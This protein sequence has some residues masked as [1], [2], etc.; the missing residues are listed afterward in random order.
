VSAAKHHARQIIQRVLFDHDYR[1]RELQRL[2]KEWSKQ[3]HNIYA[4]KEAG[5]PIPH[6]ASSEA[7]SELVLQ[8]S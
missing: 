2:L 6:G 8:G 7:P 4:E 5:Q 1:S 3:F